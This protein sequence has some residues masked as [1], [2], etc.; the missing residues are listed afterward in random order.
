MQIFGFYGFAKS[1]LY[2][3]AFSSHE[4][5]EE[6]IFALNFGNSGDFEYF[7]DAK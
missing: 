4:R 5:N 6:R 1:D 3:M 2:E 7:E